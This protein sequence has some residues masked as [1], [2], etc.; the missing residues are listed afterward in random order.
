MEIF[1]N[2]EGW[3]DEIVVEGI[4]VAVG[5]S[6]FVRDLKLEGLI[7]GRSDTGIEN[8]TVLILLLMMMK[9]LDF[10]R[11]PWALKLLIG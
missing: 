10:W 4:E 8:R 11:F 3:L 7:L 5:E 9:P 1:A 2:G 6:A